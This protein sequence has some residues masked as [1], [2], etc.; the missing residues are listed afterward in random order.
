MHS[1]FVEDNLIPVLRELYYLHWGENHLVAD[2]EH[3]DEL[4]KE[5]LQVYQLRMLHDIHRQMHSRLE[6]IQQMA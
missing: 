1:Q 4:I 6:R 5:Q 3:L 2:E